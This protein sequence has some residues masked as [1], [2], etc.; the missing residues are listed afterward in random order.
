MAALS[1]T[2]LLLL[3]LEVTLV[4]WSSGPQERCPHTTLGCVARSASSFLASDCVC[5][6]ALEESLESVL[7]PF[8]SFLKNGRFRNVTYPW[9]E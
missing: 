4:H 2:P 5:V 1:L 7:I 8:A 9:L 6:S 3:P